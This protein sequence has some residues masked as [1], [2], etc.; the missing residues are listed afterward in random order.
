MEIKY[1]KDR[2]YVEAVFKIDFIVWKYNFKFF[3]RHNRL[4]LKQTLQYGNPSAGSRAVNNFLRF[5]IDFIVWKSVHC[6]CYV[7]KIFSLKQ[8]LQYGNYVENEE[9][10]DVIPSLKQT[11]QYGNVEVKIVQY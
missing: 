10:N 4:R 8:T 9:M 7:F 2:W 6:V 1:E 3:I 11:L 5:K